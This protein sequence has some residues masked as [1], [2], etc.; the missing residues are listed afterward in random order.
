MKLNRLLRIG[1]M[2]MLI[3]SAVIVYFNL[4]LL[5]E[6]LVLKK[7]QIDQVVGVNPI[8]ISVEER[9]SEL[10][11]ILFFSSLSLI[12]TVTV[13]ISFIFIILSSWKK[14]RNPTYP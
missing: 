2:L 7:Y 12:Y 1:V 10:K 6:A 14:V 4:S 3:F 13:I 9:E 8:S 11:Q 5:M